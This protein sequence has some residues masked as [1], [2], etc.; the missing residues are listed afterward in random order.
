LGEPLPPGPNVV[1]VIEPAFLAFLVARIGGATATRTAG[2]LAFRAVLLPAEISTAD[3]EDAPAKRAPQLVQRDFL[4][5]PLCGRK[6]SGRPGLL[7]LS[8]PPV[9]LSSA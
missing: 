6:E 3:E 1:A 8:S 9:K 2:F 7:A 4:F 5:H